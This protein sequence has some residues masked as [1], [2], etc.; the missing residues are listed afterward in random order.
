MIRREFLMRHAHRMVQ[1]GEL[2]GEELVMKLGERRYTATVVSKRATVLVLNA[3]LA[4][5]YFGPQ[6]DQIEAENDPH[7]KSD[8]ELLLERKVKELKSKLKLEAFGPN[9]LKKTQPKARPVLWKRVASSEVPV[10]SRGYP[11][12]VKAAKKQPGFMVNR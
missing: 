1:P 11:V 4:K 8:H 9:Y 7:R 6:A 10:I 3:A 5:R 12:E 2:F